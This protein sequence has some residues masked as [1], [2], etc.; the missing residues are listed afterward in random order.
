MYVLTKIEIEDKIIGLLTEIDKI[1]QRY[2]L[3]SSRS[4]ESPLGASQLVNDKIDMNLHNEN[5]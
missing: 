2:Y 5:E 4:L 3:E 1:L